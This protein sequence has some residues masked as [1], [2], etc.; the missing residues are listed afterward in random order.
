MTAMGRVFTPLEIDQLRQDFPILQET[1]YGKPLVYLDN[2][3]SAQK[4]RHVIDCLVDVAE[5]GYANVHRGL[6]YL[7]NKATD[8][9]EAARDQVAAFLNAESNQTI[10]FTAGA[11][12]AINMVASSYLAPRIKP[13]DEIIL[14]VL[15]HHANIVPWHFLRERYGAVLKWV[16]LDETGYFDLA[17][18]QAAFT[19]RTVFVALSHMSNVLGYKMPVSEIVSCAEAHNVP[20]LLDGCQGAVHLAPDVQDLGCDFYVMSGHK[21]YGPTGVGV[22][23]GK[24]Q[25]LADM[26]PYR[27]GGEMIEEVHED[28]VSYA[29]LPHRLEAGTP[30]IMETIA[31]GAA[32]EYLSRFDPAAILAHEN[33]LGARAREALAQIP[34]VTLMGPEAQASP[35]VSFTV[36]GAHA[37]DISAL[38]D[39]YG[40]AVRAGHHCAQ[41]LMRRLGVNATARASFAMYNTEAEVDVFAQSLAKAIQFFD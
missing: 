14:S 9:F 13:G 31:L 36:E 30:A 41:P 15:E 17:A 38:L 7:S 20:V 5:H 11:T 23:Y 25:R 26:R 4:P 1:P 22:L 2:A 10:V 32:L 16:P 28:R 3:A 37:H 27:G 35:I 34:K 24:P 12:D 40:V 33:A 39:R 6:H 19:D 8:R 29:G 18:Y 21:L